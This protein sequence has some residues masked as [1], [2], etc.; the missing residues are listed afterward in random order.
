MKECDMKE[1][2]LDK[3]R[4][5]ISRID[6]A[7]YAKDWGDWARKYYGPNAYKVVLNVNAEYNDEGYST[8][9]EDVDVYN[10][11]GQKL[12]PD[13]TSPA[14][15]KQI[16]SERQVKLPSLIT[17]Y[18]KQFPMLDEATLA[19]MAEADFQKEV[20]EI[21]RYSQNDDLYELDYPNNGDVGSDY[22]AKYTFVVADEE[23]IVPKFYVEE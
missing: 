7:E 16:E 23:I 6:S 10:K 2:S 20:P 13:Q 1:I 4:D 19:T 9:L 15:A 3:I 11:S 17:K 21:I 18:K 5:I 12:E 8:N 22:E 14:I